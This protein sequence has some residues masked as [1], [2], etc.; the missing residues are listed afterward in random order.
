[1]D[2]AIKIIIEAIIIRMA[3]MSDESKSKLLAKLKEGRER[4]KKA[5]E[6]AK[7]KGLPDPKPR[8]KRVSKKA[9]DGA[10]ANPLAD[11]PANETIAPIDS[12]PAG[13]VNNVAAKPVDPTET[14]TKPIDVPNLPGEGKKVES[15]KDIVEDA[16]TEPKPAPEKGLSTTGKPEKYNDNVVLRERETGNQVIPAQYPGQKDS[17]KKLLKEN[18]ETHPL[19]N[20]PDPVPKNVTVKKVKTHVPDIKALEEKAPF[21]YSA[22]R[23][24]LY[25]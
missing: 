5:R 6:E 13:A 12:A 10:L 3:P 15:K 25:Q 24:L 8:K 1:M 17:I 21:S 22:I 11:K 2:F 7:A 18:K 14:K 19:S 9:T 16:E 20:A 4:V 23:K